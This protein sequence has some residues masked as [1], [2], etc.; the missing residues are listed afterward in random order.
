MEYMQLICYILGES[1][2]PCDIIQSTPGVDTCRDSDSWHLGQISVR[3]ISKTDADDSIC[4]HQNRG[5]VASL[6][7]AKFVVKVLLARVV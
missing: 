5:D 6:V 4:G 7:D 2:P 1:D 3:R